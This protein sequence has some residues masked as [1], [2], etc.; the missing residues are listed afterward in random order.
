MKPVVKLRFE[1][2]GRGG[3]GVTVLY[4]IS[5]VED[6]QEFAKDLKQKTGSGGTVK[7]ETIEIQGDKRLL[8]RQLL[9]KKSFLVKG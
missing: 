8:I 5:G 7:D 9:E 2:K 1:K 4:D 3:K 6:L